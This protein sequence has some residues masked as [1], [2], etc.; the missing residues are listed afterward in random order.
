MRSRYV[1]LVLA[2]LFVVG[3]AL[4]AMA[5]PG[6]QTPSATDPVADLLDQLMASA[7]SPVYSD[8]WSIYGNNFGGPGHSFYLGTADFNPLH[9]KT[10]GLSRMVVQETGEVTVFSDLT[11]GNTLDVGQN[12]YFDGNV[13]I[14]TTNPQSRLDVNGVTTTNVLTILGGADLVEGFN[15]S[16]DAIIEPGTVM[17][18]DPSNSGALMTSTESYDFK[19]A[20]VVSGANGVN[21]G[22]YLGQ[23][24]VMDGDVM[25]AM[26]GRVY[27]KCSTANGPIRPG[28]RLTTASLAGHAMKATDSSRSDGAVIGKAMSSLDEGTGLVLVLVNLQ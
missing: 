1:P 19:V 8:T 15:A 5:Q 20:G 7:L 3:V 10:D 16:D 28:D 11:V 25:V 2:M 21:P 24:S 23:D 27:V 17:V 14:G 9:L 4:T 6:K 12:A 26:T 13:G 18:I 22:I